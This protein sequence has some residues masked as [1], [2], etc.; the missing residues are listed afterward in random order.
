MQPS[1]LPVYL[2]ALAATILGTPADASATREWLAL[3]SR[4]PDGRRLRYSLE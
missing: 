3:E 1:P 4:M 2:V